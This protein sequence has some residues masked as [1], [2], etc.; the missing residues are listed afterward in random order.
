MRV[1]ILTTSVTTNVQAGGVQTVAII[2]ATELSKFGV[3]TE[4]H[5]LTDKC[6]YSNPNFK[7]RGY[8]SWSGNQNRKLLFSPYAILRT[9]SK[10]NRFDVIHVHLAVDLF[11]LPIAFLLLLFRKKLV[12]QTHGMITSKS[13]KLPAIGFFVRYILHK[14]RTHVV[15]T[16]TEHSE[17]NSVSRNG[18]IQKI[19]NPVN[20]QYQ[21]G[22]ILSNEL[23]FISRFHSRK[24]PV[25]LIEAFAKVQREAENFKLNLR[26]YGQDQ[27]EKIL[28]VQKIKDLKCDSKVSI[29]ESLLHEEVIQKLTVGAALILPSINE[30]FPMIILEAVGIGCPVLLTRDVEFAAELSQ[31]SGALTF[32][33]NLEGL[34]KVIKQFNEM[35]SEE[36]Y[37]MSQN[38]YHWAESKFSNVAYREKLVDLYLSEINRK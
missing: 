32:E 34:I 16:E 28:M 30:P 12:V 27:G 22:G 13:L 26:F 19:L 4:L 6:G 17:I 14:P 18:S 36:R 24:Q 5:F 25:V 23:M 10:A 35:S 15:L 38:A 11:T 29:G 8:R 33:P 7:S 1:L 2:Q 37:L 3:K 21:W 9:L 31:V 20:T